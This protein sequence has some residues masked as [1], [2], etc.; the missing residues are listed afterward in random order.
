MGAMGIVLMLLAVYVVV[1]RWVARK[2][3]AIAL[4]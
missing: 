1:Y 4:A 2:E 3:Q